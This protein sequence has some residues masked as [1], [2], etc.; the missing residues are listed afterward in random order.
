MYFLSMPQQPHQARGSSLSRLHDHTRQDSSGIVISPTQRPLP[1][2]M[3]YPQDT[4][5]LGPGRIR[6][7]NP[8]KRAATDPHLRPRGHWGRLLN[9]CIHIYI[10]IYIYIFF[11]LCRCNPTRAMASSF[12]RFFQITHNDASQSVRLLWTSD[13]LVAETST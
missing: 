2:N 8:S 4:K 1:H 7:R 9:V 13:Q 11:F 10:Y 3:N 5:F 6:I 12:L